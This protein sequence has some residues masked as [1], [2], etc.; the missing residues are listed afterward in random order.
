MKIYSINKLKE[1]ISYQ[2]YPM[3]SGIVSGLRV[4][5]NVSNM[6]SISSSLSNYKILK[7]IR[8]IPISDFDINLKS[9]FYSKDDFDRAKNLSIQIKQ[10]R[11]ISPLIVVIDSSGPYILE[12]A[13]RIYALKIL[14][15][16]SFPALVFIDEE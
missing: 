6:N 3:S 14:G 1:D 4:M 9:F 7:G 15:V 12:G 10:S 2:S 5:D 16:S 8:E 11:E 13:H